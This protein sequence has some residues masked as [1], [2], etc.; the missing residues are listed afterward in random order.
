VS[1]ESPN[2]RPVAPYTP[3]VAGGIDQEA[4]SDSEAPDEELDLSFDFMAPVRTIAGIRQSLPHIRAL[5][6][7][8]GLAVI[9]VLLYHL[10][11]PWMP[12]GFLGVSLFFTLSG[13][14]ITSLLLAEED[15]VGSIDFTAFW[16]RRFRRLLPAAWV[17]VLL[18]VVATAAAGEAEQLRR[19]P[20]DAAAALA[21][22]ANWRFIFA[23][24][25]YTSSYQAPSPLLHYWSLAI[26][27]QFYLVFPV[28]VALLVR[29]RASKRAWGFVIGGLLAVSVALTAL[30]YD[31]LNTARVYF[32]SFT[33]VGEILA[34]VALAVAFGRWW[35]KP[36][37]ERTGPWLAGD[38]RAHRVL[39][40][41]VPLVALVATLVL[42]TVVHTEDLWL[43][44]GGLFAVAGVSCVLV[45][46][47]LLNG[48]A[49][50]LLASWPLAS[51]GLISY[52]VYVYHWPLFQWINTT[53]TGLDGAPLAAARLGATMVAALIS[54]RFVE[55]PLRRGEIGFTLGTGAVAMAFAV[56]V[57]G[58][59]VWLSGTARQRAIDNARAALSAA[60]IVTRPPVTS[61]TAGAPPDAPP[62]PPPRRVLLMGDSLLHQSL[63]LVVD[64]LAQ[65]GTQVKAIGGP[66]QT[67]LRHQAAWLRELDEALDSFRPDV[68]VLESCCGH[69]DPKDPY[70]EDGRPLDVDSEELWRVW[71]RTVDEAIRLA[72]SRS[73]AV[74]WALVPPARTNGFYGPIE[75]RIVRANRIA[76][77]ATERHPDVGL[78]DW[79][80]LTG[81][82]G[83]YQDSLPDRTGRLVPVR[84]PDGFHFADAG[85][86]V[87]A[88][89]TRG[90]VDDAWRAANARSLRAPRS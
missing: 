16:V 30:L 12:G 19:L 90:A 57:V 31:P 21:Q 88:E 86:K 80:V 5:D 81:P 73:T 84:A 11:L 23:S 69:Y 7:L 24:D 63:D 3:S 75:D 78:L 67:L 20:G 74:L 29:G 50:R 42:W 47:V 65:Q 25:T 49:T 71:E 72:R 2:G 55:R 15:R 13:F 77:A 34:G 6:G 26:E 44:Q 52:G 41:L 58:S 54:H 36:V 14:L 87:L 61:P 66:S 45:A 68:V 8:R 56:I 27:E 17:G 38:D 40:A 62:V 18:A 60:Q 46:G 32:N 33:R 4:P 28:L 22:L 85:K 89:L 35:T 53:H 59:S 51:M 64:E 10:D 9:G 43:Y 83:E 82:N 39:R 48:P 70:V 37:D 1:P 76:V 79:G